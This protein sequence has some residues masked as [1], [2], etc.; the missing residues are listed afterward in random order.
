VTIKRD[1]D[2]TNR[3]AAIMREAGERCIEQGIFPPGTDI[4]P[5]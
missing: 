2:D 5:S 4:S 3:I 1:R